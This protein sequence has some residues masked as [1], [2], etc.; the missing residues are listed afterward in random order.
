MLVLPPA[1][2]QHKKLLCKPKNEL[3]PTGT[4]F[5]ISHDS[6][7]KLLFRARAAGLALA[8]LL[9][10]GRMFQAASG[11]GW[12]A[13]HVWSTRC[14]SLGVRSPRWLEPNYAQQPGLLWEPSPAAA[15]VTTADSSCFSFKASQP[16]TVPCMP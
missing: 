11:Q 1:E 15:L 7:N 8:A 16:S 14:I 10:G 6:W 4:F 3:N 2:I 9:Y 5:Y 12:H 13:L